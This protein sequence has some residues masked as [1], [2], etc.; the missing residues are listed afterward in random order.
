MTVLSDRHF[1]MSRAFFT[2]VLRINFQFSIF[3]CGTD[4][5][6]PIVPSGAS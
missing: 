6:V 2:Q 5:T 4:E 3:N 1:L